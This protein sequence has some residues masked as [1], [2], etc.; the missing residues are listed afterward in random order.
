MAVHRL[1]AVL[2]ALPVAAAAQ[3]SPHPPR[4][5]A[6]E[7]VL[8]W[9]GPVAGL[10]GYKITVTKDANHCG[11]KKMV[12]T[13]PSKKPLLDAEQ[14]AV[15]E[16]QVPT[17]LS[18]DPAPEKKAQ[19]QKSL[20][21]FNDFLAQM[22]KVSGAAR[23]FYSAKI[24][25]KVDE[26]TVLAS[27]ARIVQMQVHLARLMRYAEIPKDVRTGEFADEKKAAF[28]DQMDQVVAPI[29]DA[30]RAAFE[31]CQPSAARFPDAWW[32]PV[33]TTP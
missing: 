24:A 20:K 10:P 2:V 29:S 19:T 32:A 23:D 9:A 22:R 17:G 30:A 14:A 7:D 13:R 27:T 1:A 6:L 21:R 8:P 16:L 18:F 25:A 33:C 5:P 12:V 11:G 26:E 4:P 31:K 15:F 28:C 3:P